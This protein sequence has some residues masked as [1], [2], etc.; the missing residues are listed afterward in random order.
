MVR[1]LASRA[2]RCGVVAG[3]GLSAIDAMLVV[4]ATLALGR[5]GQAHRVASP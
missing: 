4:Q 1:R 3:G 5:R 2:D